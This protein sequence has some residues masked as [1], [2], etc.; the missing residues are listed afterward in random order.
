MATIIFYLSIVPTISI[1]KLIVY[2]RIK[3]YKASEPVVCV[4]IYVYVH[5]MIR[6]RRWTENNGGI[7]NA[8]VSM[9]TIFFYF[10]CC[11][12]SFASNLQFLYIQ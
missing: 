2:K 3:I 12:T 9:T 8:T 5:G 4:Y 7:Q 11:K 10:L 6:I 1:S